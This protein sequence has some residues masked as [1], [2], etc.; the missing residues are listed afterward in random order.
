MLILSIII[1]LA[2]LTMVIIDSILDAFANFIVKII[3]AVR[4][5]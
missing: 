2:T 5:I 4:N 3:K 1:V